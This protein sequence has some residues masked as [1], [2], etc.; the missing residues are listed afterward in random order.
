MKESESEL[1]WEKEEK[2]EGV[3]Y[4]TV[5]FREGG[6][7]MVKQ[8]RDSSIAP[9]AVKCWRRKYMMLLQDRQYTVR[10]NLRQAG[11]RTSA[12]LQK[13]VEME[14]VKERK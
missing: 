6:K 1:N 4:T 11:L 9:Q 2:I 7:C 3:A 10:I 13:V 12:V 14:R 5:G 8:M